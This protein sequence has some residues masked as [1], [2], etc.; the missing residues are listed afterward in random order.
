MSQRTL[1]MSGI[2][3][4]DVSKSSDKR[5]VDIQVSLIIMTIQFQK[6]DK[7]LQKSLSVSKPRSMLMFQKLLQIKRLTKSL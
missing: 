3:F 4:V 7:K 2:S 1:A 6:V 5:R